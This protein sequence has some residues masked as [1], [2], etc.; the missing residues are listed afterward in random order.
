MKKTTIGILALVILAIPVLAFGGNAIYKELT[1]RRSVSSWNYLNDQ[2]HLL[3]EK[4]AQIEREIVN[5]SKEEE[6]AFIFMVKTK[7]DQGL[8]IT[9]ESRKRYESLGK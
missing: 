6:A 4:K 3:E 8:A 2:R 1:L 7:K 5:N 9:D